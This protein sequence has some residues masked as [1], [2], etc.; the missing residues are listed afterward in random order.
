MGRAIHLLLSVAL[1]TGLLVFVGVVFNLIEMPDEH[2]SFGE[3]VCGVG[4]VDGDGVPD[5]LVADPGFA[6]LGNSYSANEQRG[7]VWMISGKDR[8][9]IWSVASDQLDDGFGCGLSRFGDV[10][11][12]GVPD[13][14]VGTKDLHPNRRGSVRVLCGKSGEVIRVFEGRRQGDAFG[15]TVEGLGDVDGDG[16][17]DLAIGSL[18]LDASNSFGGRVEVLSGDTGAVLHSIDCWIGGYY[19]E[20][21]PALRLGDVNGDGRADFVVTR[22]LDESDG[23]FEVRSGLDFVVLW[24]RAADERKQRPV[25]TFDWNAD[26]VLDL[27][28]VGQ[29]KVHVRSG[30]DGTRLAFL[31]L[32]T[33]GGRVRVM[34]DVDGDLV[35]DLLVPDPDEGVAFGCVRLLSGRDGRELYV[36]PPSDGWH[37]GLFFDPVGDLDGDGVA[38][39]VAGGEHIVSR[40]PGVYWVHSGATGQRIGR[41]GRLWNYIVSLD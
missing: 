29:H 27:I 32:G 41:Y 2:S 1:V 7:R 37:F 9:T 13:C 24:S 16:V 23:S 31:D 39:F 17:P 14:L 19:G 22:L 12:D 15:I 36:T 28:C 11:G 25:S 10:N 35:P 20:S 8:S 40:G 26:G 21:R 18:G 4:D 30:A 33:L 34:N 6:V 5:W 38:D 3:G